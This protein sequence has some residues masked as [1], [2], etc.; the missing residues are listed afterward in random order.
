MWMRYLIFN[1]NAKWYSINLLEKMYEKIYEK[2][3]NSLN[4]FIIINPKTSL[5]IHM[6]ILWNV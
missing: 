4:S 6:E 1:V 3:T 2:V 5:P